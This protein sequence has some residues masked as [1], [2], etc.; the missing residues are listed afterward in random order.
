M[1][2]KKLKTRDYEKTEEITDISSKVP[3][4]LEL[5]QQQQQQQQQSWR[6]NRR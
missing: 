6:R 3:Y 4:K 5:I 2:H 1:W